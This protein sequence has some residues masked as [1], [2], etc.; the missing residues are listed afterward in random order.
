MARSSAVFGPGGT[1]SMFSWRPAAAHALLSASESTAPDSLHRTMA[2][3]SSI[4]WPATATM[5]PMAWLCPLSM[6]HALHVCG[7]RCRVVVSFDHLAITRREALVAADQ[8]PDHAHTNRF[9]RRLADVTVGDAHNHAWLRLVREQR[10]HTG[11]HVSAAAPGS[12]FG[13]VC[14]RFYL[15]D[16]ASFGVASAVDH[17][18]IERLHDAANFARCLIQRRADAIA[19]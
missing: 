18:G 9:G 2:P 1:G 17:F 15:A 13:C 6:F 16:L 12:H 4:C 5:P 11:R 14:P 8:A 10:S 19:H 3:A 7:S